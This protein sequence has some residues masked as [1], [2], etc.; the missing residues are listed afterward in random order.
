MI[1]VYNFS[2]NISTFKVRTRT[3]KENQIGPFLKITES[4]FYR[5]W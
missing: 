3:L 5:F 4:K 2:K 1:F